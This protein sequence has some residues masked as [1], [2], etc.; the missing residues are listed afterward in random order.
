M[1]VLTQPWKGGGGERRETIV[2]LRNIFGATGLRLAA[3]LLVGM[4][5]DRVGKICEQL[6]SVDELV[7]VF[8]DFVSRFRRRPSPSDGLISR[9]NSNRKSRI[10]TF[11]HFAPSR[12]RALLQ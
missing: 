11:R 5:L 4:L 3:C 12:P 6:R 8:I 7:G 2:D 9:L 1:K 10:P